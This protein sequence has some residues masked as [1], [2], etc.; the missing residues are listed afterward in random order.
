MFLLLSCASTDPSTSPHDYLAAVPSTSG[1]DAIQDQNIVSRKL[2]MLFAP[3]VD[4]KSTTRAYQ[5]RPHSIFSEVTYSKGF[6][7]SDGRVRVYLILD[8]RDDVLCISR[9][10]ITDVL[11]G[12]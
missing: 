12:N 2:D 11:G 6:P 3:P 9:K 7:L 10:Q 8:F 1:H 5:P 4:Q